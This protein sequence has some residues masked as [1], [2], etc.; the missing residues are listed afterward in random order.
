[1][2]K[3]N[4]LKKLLKEGK[5]CIGTWSVVPS[6]SAANILGAAG[7][8]FVIID[9]E[10]GPVSF[11]LAE[12]MVRALEG[13][14]CAPLL[15]VS[16]NEAP[17]IL[18]ALEIGAH[19][20]VVPQIETAQQAANV[21]RAV[22]YMPLGTRGV[23]VFTRSS[24]YYAVGQKGRTD[25]ENKETM[26]VVLVEGAEGIKNLDA[27]LRVKNIDVVYIG[28]YDLSQ[29]LGIPDRVDS[30]KV[31]KEVEICV[32]KIRAAGVAAGVLALNEK[33]IKKWLNIGIQFIPYMAD[34]GI[35]Y[36]A[37]SEVISKFKG[38]LL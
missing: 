23:S 1:M 27:I 12:D 14:S 9:M 18:R 2:R 8:D 37:C 29:S 6:A 19:G 15:R 4:A 32:K 3:P 26:T 25:K 5:S 24:G 22:K 16:S 11:D 34:C 20:I 13:E 7:F 17:L 10:H 35:F 28:T 38:K 31:I 33:D 21:A 30:P 36:K